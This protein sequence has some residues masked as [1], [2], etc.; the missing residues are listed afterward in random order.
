LDQPQK[1][2]APNAAGGGPAG[3]GG[4][5]DT[6]DS[7]AMSFH[8]MAC[9]FLDACVGNWPDDVL[10]P[11]ALAQIKAMKPMEVFTGFDKNFGQYVDKLS[12]RDPEGIKLAASVALIE[13]LQ[14]EAKFAASNKATQDTVWSYITQLCKF[15]SVAKLYHHMPAPVLGAV[16]E[17]AASLKARLES[18]ETDLSKINPFELGQEVMSRFDPE[19]MQKMMSDMF[20]NPEAMNAVMAQM[21]GL[22]GSG[23]PGGGLGGLPGLGALGLGGDGGLPGMD[24]E[25][26]MRLMGPSGPSKRS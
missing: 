15:H 24:L 2:Q 10:L 25:A 1:M 16:N 12:R 8:N 21:S 17:A 19:E 23:L 20:K 18:G 9:Q 4:A 11:I 26:M 5:R 14:A 3:V 7:I 22:L 13:A 6:L